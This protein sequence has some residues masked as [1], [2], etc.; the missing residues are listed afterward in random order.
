MGLT[1]LPNHKKKLTS[2]KKIIF[3]YYECHKSGNRDYG[4]YFSVIFQTT[5]K[6]LIVFIR[7]I[8]EKVGIDRFLGPRRESDIGYKL[9]FKIVLKGLG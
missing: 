5:G 4:S 6:F 1:Y 3:I 7:L 9:G 2:D 8:L